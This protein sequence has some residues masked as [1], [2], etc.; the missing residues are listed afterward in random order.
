MEG[1]KENIKEEMKVN[2][3]DMEGSNYIIKNTVTKKDQNLSK[4]KK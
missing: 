4:G 3:E 2:K 1:K